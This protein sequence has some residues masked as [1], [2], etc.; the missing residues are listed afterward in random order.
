MKAAVAIVL[1]VAT[2][3]CAGDRALE[4]AALPDLGQN[5]SPSVW[6]NETSR[7]TL[8]PHVNACIDSCVVPAWTVEAG[9]RNRTVVGGQALVRAVG[10]SSP[11]DR[12]TVQVFRHPSVLGS[13]KTPVAT[14]AGILPLRLSLENVTVPL[15]GDEWL[16]LIVYPR[17]E[18]LPNLRVFAF[19]GLDVEID[20]RVLHRASGSNEGLS[21]AREGAGAGG[22]VCSVGS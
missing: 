14:T 21:D 12:V 10:P 20:F 9:V 13:T 1:V 7:G 6:T 17:G 8:P 16:G 15:R 18:D 19:A 4:P 2:A 3:G 5:P 11:C 22:A